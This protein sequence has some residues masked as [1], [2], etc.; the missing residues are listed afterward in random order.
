MVHSFLCTARWAEASDTKETIS[1]SLFT[2][3][4]Q[5]VAVVVERSSNAALAVSVFFH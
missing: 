1:A 4:F 3:P 5:I 2:L